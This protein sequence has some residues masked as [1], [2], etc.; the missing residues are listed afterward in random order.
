MS[1]EDEDEMLLALRK[2]NLMV[3]KGW[4]GDV[5]DLTDEQH[6]ELDEIIKEQGEIGEEEY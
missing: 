2:H 3:D 6:K 1:K 5:E 4:K